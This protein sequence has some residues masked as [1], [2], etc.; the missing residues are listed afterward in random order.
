MVLG[1]PPNLVSNFYNTACIPPEINRT[2]ITLIPKVNA[3]Q[4]IKDYRPISL[5]NVIYKVIAKSLA[6]RIKA[7]LPHII[8]PSQTAF[9]QGRHIATSI[10]IAQEIIHSFNLKS[11]KHKAFLLKVDLAKAFDRIEW[12]FIISALKR[13]GFSD[14]FVTLVY[15]CISSTSMAVNI[16]GSLTDYFI[17]QRGI[18]QGCPLSPYLFILAVNELAIKLQHMSSDHDIQGITLGPGCPKIHCLMFVDDLIICGQATHAEAEK[19]KKVLHNFCIASG[20]TPN[21]SKSS[22]LLSKNV[23]SFAQQQVRSVFPVQ[24]LSPN[25]IYLGHPLIF[26][27]KDRTCAYN[28]VIN[29]FK[30]KLTKLKANKLNHAGRLTYINSVL[31]SI[32]IY[33][34]ATILFSKG[35]IAKITSITRKFWWSGVQDENRESGFSF[36]S[37]KDICRPKEEGG[38]GIRDLRLVNK[39]L[40]LNA[41][42]KVALGKSS[43]LSAILKSKYYPNTSFWKATSHPVTSA[44]W[45][46]AMAVKATLIQN[47]KVQISNGSSCIWS[48]PWCSDWINIHD[49]LKLPVT[50]RPLPSKISDL[51]NQDLIHAIFDDNFASTISC[52]KPISN[53]HNDRIVWMPSKKGECSTKDAFKFLNNH[54][55]VHLPAQGPRSISAH[56]L[57]LLRR[58]WN[59][60]YLPP[61]IKTFLWRLIRCAL[62]TSN[63]AG[64]L[65][66]K[67]ST[68]CTFCGA[69]ETDAHIFFTCDFARAV[70]FSSKSPLRSTDLPV[71][72]DGVQRSLAA[73]IPSTISDVRLADLLS[74]LWYIWK[75][76]NELRFGGKR[77]SVL[78]VHHAAK[79]L[80]AT[81]RME[82]KAEGE[83]AFSKAT[84][85]TMTVCNLLSPLPQNAGK[86]IKS[87]MNKEDASLLHLLMQ[88][89]I[90]M[91]KISQDPAE[92]F[93]C[94]TDAAILPDDINLTPRKVGIGIH[95]ESCSAK[96]TLFVAAKLSSC[97]SVLEAEALALLTALQ[98]TLTIGCTLLCAWTC[99]S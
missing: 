77:W 89:N 24:D 55:Q 87:K 72:H 28:F 80:M 95:F 21:L 50:V 34:M 3:P 68:N 44:F 71:E 35:F 45:S 88:V 46:S 84:H 17:P 11:W 6:D 16:N 38:L 52:L 73:M 29:K 65:A 91:E 19:I 48:T 98:N 53:N 18:R 39:S 47:F 10:I 54:V 26:N 2:H 5:C 97:Y 66:P 59:L 33:Y 42:W 79:T 23:D 40:I 78:Q 64:S 57:M 20:Q 99:L 76:R 43:Y 22:I 7:H 27:H 31:A 56:S 14:K 70:W 67:I 30:M 8:H 96:E 51:W 12:H 81:F 74:T 60:K 49:H 61:V 13:Q 82:I 36:R 32:P 63:R 15:S 75:A 62:A 69:L 4:T 25:T 90:P 85:S 93:S 92:G 37:W 58:T 83:P 1:I 86:C 94:Y 41:A 9:I